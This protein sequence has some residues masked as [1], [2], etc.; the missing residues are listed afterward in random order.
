[1]NG[2][3]IMART[4]WSEDRNGP[5]MEPIAGTIMNRHE[6]PM[7]P[8]WWG[9]DV[10]GICLHPGQFSGWSWKDPNFRKLLTVTDTDPYFRRALDI[11]YRALSGLAIDRA[12]GAS[13]YYAKSM[14]TPPAWAVG[15]TPCYESDEHIFLKIGPG[16]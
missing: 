5:G 12:N 11:S 13:H 1:M 15:H 16:A 4:L 9:E 8:Y 6:W 7:G 2:A 10:V 14:K 3:E